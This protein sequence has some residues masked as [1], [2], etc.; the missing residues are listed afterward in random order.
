MSPHLNQSF[1]VSSGAAL[2]A[3][4]MPVKYDGWLTITPAFGSLPRA[5]KYRTK[6]TPGASA[7]SSAA[8]FGL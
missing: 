6:S 8:V 7:A 2:T 3:C 5:V 1:S 4:A